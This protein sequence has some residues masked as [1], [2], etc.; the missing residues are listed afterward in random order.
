MVLRYVEREEKGGTCVDF[1]SERGAWVGVT[2]E[3][4]RRPRLD[5]GAVGLL[6]CGGPEDATDA[7]RRG[8]LVPVQ[9]PMYW[10]WV[11]G[12]VEDCLGRRRAGDGGVERSRCDALGLGLGNGACRGGL[13]LRGVHPRHVFLGE[14]LTVPCHAAALG[15]VDDLRASPEKPC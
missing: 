1:V 10:Y 5:R 13:G 12:V 7:L 15:S 4:P 9:V 3:R 11:P 2:H 6:R 8:F 14:E